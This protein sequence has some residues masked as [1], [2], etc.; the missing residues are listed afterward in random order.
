[1]GSWAAW[2]NPSVKGRKEE[3]YA[4]MWALPGDAGADDFPYLSALE[5]L[6]GFGSVAGA[7]IRNWPLFGLINEHT[8]EGSVFGASSGVRKDP[9][10]SF[11]DIPGLYDTL[12][13]GYSTLWIYAS[14]DVP[15]IALPGRL[16][17]RVCRGLVGATTCINDF[18]STRIN[19]SGGR[20]L[21]LGNYQSS[22]KGQQLG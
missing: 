19:F 2:I 7:N 4:I 20:M 12:L 22:Q 10:I 18:L 13:F 15:P 9:L 6:L 1:M 8:T 3:G 5:S 11:Y 14:V 16:K 17:R 21:A